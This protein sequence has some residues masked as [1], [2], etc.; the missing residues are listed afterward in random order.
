MSNERINAMT[1]EVRI[2]FESIWE[3][4]TSEG[5]DEAY[6]TVCLIIDKSD[7][8]TLK[9]LKDAE[10]K[11]IEQGIK[12]KWNGKKP[13]NLQLPLH[14]GDLEKPENP[15]YENS[16]YINAKNKYQ[17]VIIDVNKKQIT[18]EN[19]VYSGCYVQ[20][21][22]NFYP[23]LAKGKAGVGVGLGAIVKRRDGDRIG[24]SRVNIDELE[25]DAL[26]YIDED[27]LPF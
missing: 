8:E 14:D 20:A 16:Y 7:K 22:L 15:N 23:Y 2:G 10:Q 27:E 12:S 25:I 18:D 19:E 13:A 24:G 9:R 21:Y 5:Q 3:A 11:A 6:Y 1:K 17:P 26:D 4:K